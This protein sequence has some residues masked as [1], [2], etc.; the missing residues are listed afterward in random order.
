MVNLVSG[1][2]FRFAFFI[3]FLVNSSVGYRFIDFLF[4]EIRGSGYSYIL[5]FSGSQIPGGD[6]NYSVRVYFESHLYLGNA[7]KRS[8]NSGKMKF[9]E[10]FVIRG[11]LAFSLENLD[12]N[13]RLKISR[14]GIYFA[15][16]YRK[17]GVSVY[18]F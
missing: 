8:F 3:F 7:S 2:G 16:F 11:H 12:V 13:G 5:T 17:S 14:G 9:P 4:T 6:M 18:Y 15:P 10:K 1:V